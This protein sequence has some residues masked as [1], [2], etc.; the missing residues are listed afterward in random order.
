MAYNIST[1]VLAAGEGRRL[2]EVT[3]GI[4]KQFWRGPG[5]YTLLENTVE[6]FSLLTPPERMAIVVGEK[7]RRFVEDDEALPLPGTMA[8]QPCD[9]GTATGVL[10]GLS[11][12]AA[13]GRDD[14][15]V[16]TPSDH[17]VADPR[18]FRNVM[19]EAVR[20]VHGRDEIVILG[21]Q[22]LKACSDYGWITPG[23]ALPSSRVRPVAS[24]VEKPPVDEARRLCATGSVWNTMIVVARTSSLLG[25]YA[26]L[27]PDLHAAFA[28][29]EGTCGPDR[30]R[31]LV[32]LYG[33]MRRSYDFSRDILGRARG[34][35]TCILPALVGWSDLGT[36]ERLWEWH[37]RVDP[38]PD[39][40]GGHIGQI[41]S[42][43]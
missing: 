24:F 6:R 38:T 37:S 27:L 19:I 34:L 18:R 17:G 41:S 40:P 29:L 13:S 4:P 7:H 39:G 8:V 21:A 15:V 32:G 42:A 16:L 31:R 22:P 43:A 23:E 35:A 25:L 12:L 26:R 1:L 11:Q 2:A 36:P 33:A 3:E 30:Y 20:H 9:R 14:L 5:G 10:L 28:E